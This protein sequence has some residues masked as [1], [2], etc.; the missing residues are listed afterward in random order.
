MLFYGEFYVYVVVFF[1]NILCRYLRMCCGVLIS[2]SFLSFFFF[3]AYAMDMD[4]VQPG[5]IRSI[6]ARAV[7]SSFASSSLNGPRNLASRSIP[8][9][10]SSGSRWS[11]FFSLFVCC[12]PLF[13]SEL[14]VNMGRD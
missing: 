4:G 7:G 6:Q 5:G 12:L 11:I 8:Q 14:E 10:L 2:V 9:P 3:V 1:C 13:F